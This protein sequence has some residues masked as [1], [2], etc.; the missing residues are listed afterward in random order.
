[1]TGR[2]GPELSVTQ[3]IAG[4]AATVTATVAASYFGVGGTL[5]GAGAVSVLSTVGATVYQRFL[6]HG[7]ER[8]V[9]RI[10]MR[11]DAR[12]PD[13]PA[14]GGGDR[15]PGGSDGDTDGRSTPRWYVLLGAAAGIFLTVMGLVTGFELFTGRPLSDTV[16]GR[17]GRGTSVHPARGSVPPI[18][19]TPAHWEVAPPVTREVSPP[20][21]LDPMPTSTPATTPAPSASTSEPVPR[22]QTSSAGSEPG[23]TRSL[24]PQEPLD[25]EDTGETP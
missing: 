24:Q 12:A 18:P 19:R 7:K 14:H 11:A 17:V 13:G 22:Q 2:H 15:G 21:S 10:P 23:T 9:A 25:G 8:L 16:Q 6:D 1:M 20:P 3:L 4:A 5:I